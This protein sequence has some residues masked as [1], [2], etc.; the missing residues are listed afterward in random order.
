MNKEIAKLENKI[1]T[2]FSIVMFIFLPIVILISTELSIQIIP[3]PIVNDISDSKLKQ[4]IGYI[5]LG[6]FAIILISNFVILIKQLLQAKKLNKQLKDKDFN[7]ETIINKN[8]CIVITLLLGIIG[9]QNIISK[10]YIRF[11]IFMII[12]CA[13]II[14]YKSPINI[15]TII[16]MSISLIDIL[17]ILTKKSK[18]GK[19][20]LLTKGVEYE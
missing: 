9:G 20:V 15:L 16:I 13:G 19:I 14:L 2:N 17:V 18:D 3:F 12:S 4:V 1:K 10:N 6:F 7:K 5:L 11:I 8:I